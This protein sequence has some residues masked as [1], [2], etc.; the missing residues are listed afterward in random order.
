MRDL[1]QETMVEYGS[2]AGVWR[3]LDILDEYRG[4]GDHLRLRRGPGAQPRCGAG[5]DPPR[6]RGHG[7]RLSLGELLGHDPRAGE[8]AHPHGGVESI[9]RTTGQRPLGWYIRSSPSL[10]TRE[11]LVEDG[12]FLYDCNAYN[13]DLP[14]Y[15][16]VNGKQWLVHSLLAGG[17]RRRL[18]AGRR[19]VEGQRPVREHGERL[20]PAVL[21]GCD[22]SPR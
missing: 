14:Y 1:Q 21:G 9:T 15:T 17:E 8:G 20:R 4:Q 11:L 2:R 10:N 16:P 5:G 7:P 12:G 19:D 22:A 18:L 13:D 3:L 6:P